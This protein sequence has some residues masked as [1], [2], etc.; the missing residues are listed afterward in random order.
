M[1]RVKKPA[2]FEKFYFR[3]VASGEGCGCAERI[4]DNYEMNRQALEL[5]RAEKKRFSLVLFWR[6]LV[7]SRR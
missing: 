2:D 4:I 1:R 7:G 6:R 3:Y 5:V